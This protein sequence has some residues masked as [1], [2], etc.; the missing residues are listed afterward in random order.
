[1]RPLYGPRKQET[2]LADGRLAALACGALFRIEFQIWHT[3]YNPIVLLIVCI[4]A[5][6]VS[7]E[8]ISNREYC[9]YRYYSQHAI[10]PM[11][12][13]VP[14]FWSGTYRHHWEPPS[15]YWDHV[16]G[17]INHRSEHRYDNEQVINV[18]RQR[19][20][21]ERVRR[22]WYWI[23]VRRESTRNETTLQGRIN[24]RS[25]HTNSSTDVFFHYVSI[26]LEWDPL[27]VAGDMTHTSCLLFW[28]C[29]DR[30]HHLARLV[31]WSYMRTGHAH[32]GGARVWNAPT[33]KCTTNTTYYHTSWASQKTENVS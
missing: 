16:Q 28:I 19:S 29:C 14:V 9:R 24:H 23:G 18:T 25:E 13:I 4:G 22:W 21:G 30:C 32:P 31:A 15:L 27:V 10:M 7:I 8:A 3:W 11:S 5:I 6:I 12:R 20:T 26:G 2:P 1:M 17:R 33:M